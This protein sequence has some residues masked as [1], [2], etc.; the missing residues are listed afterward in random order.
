MMTVGNERF[1]PIETA[2]EWNHGVFDTCAE[3]AEL[4]ERHSYRFARTMP[5]APHSYTLKRTWPVEDEFVEA[6]RKMR[7]VERIEEFFRGYWYRRF[8]ANGYKYWTMG[9]SLDHIL[10]NRAIHAS[11]FD[12][13]A[14]VYDSYDLAIHEGES[15]VERSRR[16]Y[17]SLKIEPG[18][19][20][21]DIGCGT[22]SLVDFRFRDIDPERYVGIDPS[23]GMLG[24][25]GDKHPEFRDRLIRTP[26][27]DYWPKPGQKFD[28]V[29]ALFGVPSHIGEPDL[30][31]GKVQ[32][33]LNP[34]GTAV[35]MYNGR[36]AE[37]MDFYRNLGTKTHG[38]TGA[39]V[40]DEFWTV[41]E[42]DD[43]DWLTV[44]GSRP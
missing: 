2:P 24:V 37:D 9:A 7:T 5:G 17:E 23:R 32:W 15:D 21:L 26:F 22:G 44:V 14:A 1:R 25:F 10:I 42:D 13:Y 30:L 43:P 6:L 35:L 36:K 41:Q 33:L 18:T 28:L 20:I 34:G 29:V 39:P 38:P 16:V 8:N 12:P 27:E 3:L 4:L 11:A 40:S 19:E 31:S